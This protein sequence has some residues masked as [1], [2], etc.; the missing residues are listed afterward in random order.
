MEV[1][2]T[3]MNNALFAALKPGGILIVA[4]HSAR[5]EDGANVGKLY[6]RIAETT[7]RSEVEA[8]GFKLLAEGDFLRNPDDPRTAIVFRSPIKVDEFVLKFQKP[9]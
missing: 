2:R 9:R 1:D 8:A 4:D 5:P 6:H 3:R 7:L